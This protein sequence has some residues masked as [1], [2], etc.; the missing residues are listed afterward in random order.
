[1]RVEER[2]AF[3]SKYYADIRRLYANELR[4][5]QKGTLTVSKNGN[6]LR[7]IQSYKENGKWTQKCIG[8]NPQKIRSLAR[9]AYLRE[10]IRRIDRNA[11]LLND[12][13]RSLLS[14]DEKAILRSLPRSYEAI[15]EEF[16]TCE[17]GSKT[18]CPN[19]VTDG[20]ARIREAQKT[21]NGLSPIEWGLLPY[22]ANTK[23]PEK[24]NKRLPNG[25]L[26]RSKSEGEIAAFYGSKKICYHYDET[27]RI[28]QRLLSPDFIVARPDGFLIYHEH[29]GLVDDSR[30]SR[31]IPVKFQLY[32]S[33]GIVP[34]R[35]LIVT[36]ERADEGLDYRLLE[37]E[38]DAKYSS[39][40]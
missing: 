36:Y 33:A 18:F 12:L 2:I 38:I 6:Y 24:K 15:P 22:A 31:D 5:L 35:N 7:Y 14:L 32:A 10:A 27:I 26:V 13:Q 11:L 21:T 3:L 34:W 1:M 8:K 30:Y 16:F 17:N 23:Y 19:P 4:N 28:G 25:L 29:F 39:P 9:A 40:F 37:A 20:T